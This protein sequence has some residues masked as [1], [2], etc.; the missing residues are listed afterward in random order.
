M[1]DLL[2]S[3]INNYIRHSKNIL[4]VIISDRNGNIIVT[5]I[6][7]EI[8]Q[9]SLLDFISNSL[10]KKLD[11]FIIK[12]KAENSFF[13]IKATPD[14]KYSVCSFGKCLLI[15]IAK[16]SIS[17]TE[18]KIYSINITEKVE[19]IYEGQKE[20]SLEIPEVMKI[21]SKTKDKRFPQGEHSIKIIVV[22]DFKAGKSSVIKRIIEDKYIEAH[23]PTV[24]F[25]ISKKILTIEDTNIRFSIWDTGGLVSQISPT[26]DKIY[27]HADAALIIV[28]RTRPTNI[29]SIK[30][31]YNDINNSVSKKIPI[32]II[33]TK[34]DKTSDIKLREE[35]IKTLAKEY[36]IPFIPT[37]AKTGKN[38]NRAFINLTYRIIDELTKLEPYELKS[39][40]KSYYLSSEETKALEDLENLIVENADKSFNITFRYDLKRLKVRGFPFIHEISETSYGIE[41]QNG[42]IVGIG[43][44]N[45]GLTR[46]PDSFSIFKSLKRLSLRSNP[47]KSFPEP[48]CKL[49]NLEILD[50]SLTNLSQVPSIIGNLHN[51][52]ELHLENNW[53]RTLPESF[54]Q[55]NSL[56]ILNLENNPIDHL[57]K[58]FGNLKSLKKLLLESSPF[59]QSGYMINLPK[60]FGNLQFLQEL[61][62]SSH[63]L[64]ILPESFGDLKSLK[65]LDLFNNRFKTLPNYFGNLQALEELNLERNLIQFFP[66]AFGNLSSLK[67]V[68]LKNNIITKK[69]ASKR[70]KALAFK[71]IGND[72]DRWIKIAGS[73]ENHEDQMQIIR[74]DLKENMILKNII[75]PFI[76]ACSIAFIGL[77]TFL[78]TDIES[79]KL[80]VSI[81]WILFLG[82]L[83]INLLIGTSIISTISTYFKFSISTF[84]ITAQKTVL[85]FFDVLVAVLLVWAIRAAVLAA[86]RI[87]LIPAVN[88]F[89]DFSIPQW[90]L[91]ILVLFGYNIDLTFLENIDLFLGHFYLKLFSA[92][93]VFW[94]LYRNGLSYIKKTAFDETENKNIW[95]F[96]V[97]GLFGAF[98]LAIMDYSNLKPMLSIGYYIGVSLG[99][100]VFIWEKNKENKV[101]FYLYCF[102]FGLGI[103]TVWLLSLWN[104]MI[105]FLM[106]IIF[107]ILFF[108]LRWKSHNIPL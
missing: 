103:L 64:K 96:L 19:L 52:K 104:L 106:G 49:K 55:L 42:S 21:F 107:I 78:T 34:I 63:K 44:F 54:G 99:A 7:D 58:S 85:K 31:W 87:E 102:I 10:Y 56:R 60:N 86:I 68:N 29:K 61:D 73:M 101:I 94:A 1:E 9:E 67:S 27:N 98:W 48:I 108:I 76:Y 15:T 95:A 33:G 22:G 41:I 100:F 11:E 57:P 13:K 70:F 23:N 3:L 81:I 40:Y 93:L 32:I 80:N 4:G 2:K 91:N 53:L 62:L 88:F 12:Y 20:I 97:I 36:E 6:K 89:F 77:V 50:L 51:L 59:E 26:K 14:I 65:I 5:K 74:P 72:Y 82:A 83:I 17:D 90:I 69:E 28:D 39:K 18:L 16:N 47:L 71:S 43:L 38:I 25:H 8:T 66:K 24:G 75:T 45:C 79:L 35:D 92:A 37:S 30:K 105:S 46:L 84:G